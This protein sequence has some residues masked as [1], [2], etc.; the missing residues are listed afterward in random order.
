M[1]S[2]CLECLR[3]ALPDSR[4]PVAFDVAHFLGD[5]LRD[6]RYGRIRRRTAGWFGRACWVILPE[7]LLAFRKSSTRC[8]LRQARCAVIE[9]AWAALAEGDAAARR[10]AI[11]AF[12]ELRSQGLCVLRNFA[13]SADCAPAQREEVGVAIVRLE[14]R[15]LAR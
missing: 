11:A 12:E 2:I 4:S 14:A 5:M 13:A 8:V 15:S 9:V 3:A 7:L 1:P 10:A 6:G